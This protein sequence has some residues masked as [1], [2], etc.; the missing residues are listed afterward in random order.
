[1]AKIKLWF[2][3]TVIILPHEG[4]ICSSGGRLKG[5]WRGGGGGRRWGCS[6]VEKIQNHVLGR[7]AIRRTQTTQKAQRRAELF[8][9]NHRFSRMKRI[10]KI[11]CVYPFHLWKSVVECLKADDADFARRGAQKKNKNLRSSAPSASSAFYYN[12]KRNRCIWC[13]GTLHLLSASK[14]RNRA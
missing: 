7:V 9:W 4:K 10:K 2:V 11:I 3:I 13:S 5:L 1:M 8:F 12:I 6:F 14:K